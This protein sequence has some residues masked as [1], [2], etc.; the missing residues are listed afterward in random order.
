[1]KRFLCLLLGLAF[2]LNLAGCRSAEGVAAKVSVPENTK[3]SVSSSQ[4]S[5]VSSEASSEVS[6]EVSSE[7]SSEASQ[8]TES[9]AEVMTESS[10][11]SKT[12]NTV[13]SQAATSSSK[14]QSAATSFEE[15]TAVSSKAASSKTSVSSEKPVIKGK[16]FEITLTFLGDMILGSQLETVYD[17]SFSKYANEKPADYF[18]EKVRPILEKDD[19]TI[20]NL[21]VVLSDQKLNPIEKD[22]SPAFWFKAPAKNIEILSGSSIEG[23]LLNN[24]HTGDYGTAGYND[25]VQTVTDAGIKY[26]DNSKVM[27]F[28]K[29]GFKVGVL[30]V[31][32]WGSYNTATAINRLNEM[33]KNCDYQVVMFHGGTEKIHSPEQYKI[34][35]AHKFIDN[36]ADL[37]VGGHPH[38]LQ[39]REVYKG[40]EIIYSIGNF[41]YG[42]A[43][44]PENRTVIYQQTLTVGANSLKVKYTESD[45]I[46]C[47][48]YTGTINNYQPAVI[49][50]KARYQKVLDFMDGKADSPV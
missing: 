25:T 44:Y 1:M 6:T 33:K 35:A 41:C 27:Y 14:V 12:D 29:N 13:H 50:D 16:T 20:A 21:E 26:G 28:K 9:K 43:R 46:P 24:N 15:E 2:V 7:A 4:V 22:Y 8:K 31:P 3:S 19:F 10:V 18:L 37:V 38:V 23:V 39:P 5:A 32:L 17:G 30:C 48:V 11:Q 49:K 47:Y 36:G 45:I 34:D 42:G 40:K